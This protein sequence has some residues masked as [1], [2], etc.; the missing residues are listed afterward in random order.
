MRYSSQLGAAATC[1]GGAKPG[2]AASNEATLTEMSMTNAAA[3]RLRCAQSVAE[4][5]S[6]MLTLQQVLHCESEA[7]VER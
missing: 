2:E 4:W 6:V 5:P 7:R 1:H 3:D